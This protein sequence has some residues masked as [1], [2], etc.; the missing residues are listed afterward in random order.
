[1][2][3]LAINTVLD[4]TNAPGRIM[5]K[6]SNAAIKRGDNVMIA[7]GRGDAAPNFDCYRLGSILDVY[8]HALKS[9]I[10]DSSGF[11]STKATDKLIAKLEEFSPDVV[12][13]HNLHGY[14]INVLR[15]M[16]WLKQKKV[17]IVWTLHDCWPFTGHCARYIHN[18]C[19]QWKVG[20]PKCDFSFDYPACFISQSSRNYRLKE[21]AFLG[22]E[23]LKLI[24]VSKWQQAQISQ[25]FLKG[26]DTYVIYNGIDTSFFSP[27]HVESVS[28]VIL[29]VASRWIDLKNL[30]FFTKLGISH[31]NYKILIVGD[32][33]FRQR[34]K[35]PSNMQFL[36]V[37]K[38]DCL[39][40]IYNQ[41]T[42]FINPS[43]E[44]TFGMTTIE[45]MSCGVP[46]IVNATTAMPE[47]VGHG[48]VVDIDNLGSVSTAIDYILKNKSKF[49][50][51]AREKVL[52]NFSE[53]RMTESYLS[54]Y[55][56]IAK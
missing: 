52:D 11:H 28:P 22:H 4:K 12:H 21:S 47:I 42:I 25:S 23:N 9:R 43:R 39:P 37:V 40:Q 34:L 49:G 1:M 20:C 27:N 44:E 50:A 31:P 8:G 15:L 30:E 32:T 35:S 45:A 55:D 24:A 18:N 36:G 38:Y 19:D 6:I 51:D 46:V 16:E 17:P 33:T 41:S 13:I 56:K 7:F 3:I 14:Y 53:E 29:G 48:G 26:Y 10:D 5:M 2:N 54:L